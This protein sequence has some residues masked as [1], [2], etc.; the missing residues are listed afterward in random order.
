MIVKT[1]EANFYG[2]GVFDS[3]GVFFQLTSPTVIPEGVKFMMKKLF[4]LFLCLVMSVSLVN[5]S[6]AQ[7]DKDKDTK[8]PENVIE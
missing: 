5:A 2:L 3:N 1:V 8:P 7:K 6:F 4:N